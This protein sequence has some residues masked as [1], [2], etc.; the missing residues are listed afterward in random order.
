MIINVIEQLEKVKKVQAVDNIQRANCHDP[1]QRHQ[2]NCMI[3][4][5]R[6]CSRLV[7]VYMKKQYDYK[8]CIKSSQNFYD[9]CIFPT[10]EAISN[11]NVPFSRACQSVLT[12]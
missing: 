8:V 2:L 7:C 10:I 5:G 6:D 12:V 11:K 4:E 1:E 3:R 9:N